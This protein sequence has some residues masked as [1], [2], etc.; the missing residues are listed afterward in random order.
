M[1][2]TIGLFD[3]CTVENSNISKKQSQSS[4]GLGL[5]DSWTIEC[6]NTSKTILELY[7]AWTV[8][9]LDY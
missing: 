3:Y 1:A 6:A 2:W 9:L 8:E 5:L 4:I 7:K